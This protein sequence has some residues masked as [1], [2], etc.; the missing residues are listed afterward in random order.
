[1]NGD[2]G[3]P[4][5][6]VPVPD[7]ARRPLILS[8]LNFDIKLRKS[9]HDQGYKRCYENY[10]VD[11]DDRNAFITALWF[12][13]NNLGWGRENYKNLYIPS[14]KCD[15]NRNEIHKFLLEPNVWAYTISSSITVCRE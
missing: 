4:T 10:D 12:K 6:V 13:K 8:V 14:N 15:P 1:M 5:G 9:F 2:Q 7:Y 11:D 3:N